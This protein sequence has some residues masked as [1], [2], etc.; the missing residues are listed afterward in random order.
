MGRE[1]VAVSRLLS[2]AAGEEE[3]A[4]EE[5]EEEVGIGS[6]GPAWQRLVQKWREQESGRLHTLPQ[7]TA[8]LPHGWFFT[9]VCP[10]EQGFSTRS[11]QGGQGP[12]WQGCLQGWSHSRG[13]RQDSPHPSGLNWPHNASSCPLFLPHR[14]LIS[15]LNTT[16]QGGQGPRW[17]GDEHLCPHSSSSPHCASHSL[18]PAGA[19]SQHCLLHRW[20]PHD[21]SRVHTRLHSNSNGEIGRAH[22]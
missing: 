11:T 21:S 4:R 3:E 12:G 18:C 6:Q 14:H 19:K 8:F 1:E 17:H 7:K 15:P 5:E 16:E 2:R 22:V 9:R 20:N 10:Q 13:W